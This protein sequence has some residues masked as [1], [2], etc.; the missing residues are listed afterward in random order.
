MS[1][2]SLKLTV[3]H[4]FENLYRSKYCFLLL[5][6]LNR[7]RSLDLEKGF[8]QFKLQRKASETSTKGLVTD[9][10]PSES[11]S[12]VL[13]SACKENWEQQRSRR[14][15]QKPYQLDGYRTK[16]FFGTWQALV[17]SHRNADVHNSENRSLKH[18]CI[19]CQWIS[20]IQS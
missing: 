6:G 12:Q 11:T 20:T 16:G 4:Q 3:Q 18:L 17:Y 5:F 13:S 14:W 8:Y 1:T 9:P 7:W 19:R 2:C 15:M 10:T